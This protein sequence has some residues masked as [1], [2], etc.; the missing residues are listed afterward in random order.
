MVCA[1]HFPVNFEVAKVNKKERPKNPPS[2]FDNIKKS[3]I[4][5]PPPAKRKTTKASNSIRTLKEDELGVFL[6]KDKIDS[7]ES[8]CASISLEKIGEA[9]IHYVCGDKLYIQSKEY[10][11]NTGIAKFVL[12]PSLSKNRVSGLDDNSFL[13]KIFP[14]LNSGQKK[15]IILIDEVYVKPMLTYHGGQLFGSSVNDESELAKT[16]RAFMISCLYG[17]PTFFIKMFPVNKLDSTFVYNQTKSL[18][19]EIEKVNGT[20]KAIITNNNRVNQA[21]FRKFECLFP[22]FFT[23]RYCT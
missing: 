11:N 16:V 22:W 3:L 17:G 9:V 6:K 21:F 15:C 18:C 1:N 10:E 20:V 5:T 12:C 8:I 4:P 7:F 19:E 14:K 2:I 13:N 23:F